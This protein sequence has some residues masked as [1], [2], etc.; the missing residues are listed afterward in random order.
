MKIKSNKKLI[1]QAL[2]LPTLIFA[3]ENYS[4]EHFAKALD[5]YN[6][7]AFQD[8][9][10]TF[11]EYLKKDTIDN[12]LKFM[13]AR[14]AYEIGKFEEAET[15]YKEILEKSPT[16]S[17]VK[18][19]LAQTYFQLKQYDEAK[20]LY[21]EVLKEPGL[22]QNVRKNIEFTLNSL[23]KKSQKNFLKTTLGF[24]YGFDSN[25]DN[26]S[27]DNTVEIIKAYKIWCM[28]RFWEQQHNKG[29]I[30]T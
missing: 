18:L 15:L 24:G 26:N 29:L 10:I 13:L 22:P 25:V 1:F 28:P 14:S 17:R 7:R 3:N 21:E 6:N 23:D 12:D 27:N 5:S 30:I 11:K 4:N 9:Y 8:S 20:A 16:S 2:F 19:E